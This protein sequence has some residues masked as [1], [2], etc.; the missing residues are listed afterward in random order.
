MIKPPRSGGSGGEEEGQQTCSIPVATDTFQF[1]NPLLL[2]GRE[3][4]ENFQFRC[5]YKRTRRGGGGLREENLRT[6]KPVPLQTEA[7]WKVIERGLLVGGI[8]G[9]S[10]SSLLYQIH[11][12]LIRTWRPF[13]QLWQENILDKN[14]LL[15]RR[16]VLLNVVVF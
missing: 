11:L 7:S 15:V 13:R 5:Q 16:N 4:G 6:K 1:G 2:R 12:L 14:C 3:E 8:R 10:S 9:I